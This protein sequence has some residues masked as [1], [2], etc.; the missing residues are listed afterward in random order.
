[1]H[2]TG[3]GVELDQRLG[4]QLIEQSGQTN[5]TPLGHSLESFVLVVGQ[6]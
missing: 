6:A 2:E 1:V 5:A 4:G 3:L